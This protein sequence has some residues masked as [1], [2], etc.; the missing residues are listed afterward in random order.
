M[1]LKGLP[2]GDPLVGVTQNKSPGS[3]RSPTGFF[4]PRTPEQVV[5]AGGSLRIALRRSFSGGDSKQKPWFASL[6]D[7]L[8]SAPNSRAGC[9]CR[10]FSE[11]CLAAILKWGLLKTKTLVRFAHQRV[12][13]MPQP[14]K[15]ALG[16][17][18]EKNPTAICCRV[19]VLVG[20]EGFEPPKAVPTDLQSA[21]F[22]RS[23]TPPLKQASRWRDSNP[24][25]AD[26]KSAALA[27]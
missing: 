11:D 25:P 20:E 1:V 10:W 13:F 19:F 4:Q 22:D 2:C 7:G 23:G 14:S 18:Y 9:G 16:S 26:Y 24:R 3:L 5:V 21:P 8:F 6:T 12:F 15:Q 27:N 17:G